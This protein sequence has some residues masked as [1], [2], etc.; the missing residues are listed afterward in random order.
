MWNFSP[1]KL[2]L[3]SVVSLFTCEMDSLFTAFGCFRQSEQVMTYSVRSHSVVH[4]TVDKVVKVHP[5][6][7]EVTLWGFKPKIQPPS[8]F[9]HWSMMTKMSFL[10]WGIL[11]MTE[12]S[13][14]KLCRPASS[15]LVHHHWQVGA[16]FHLFSWSKASVVVPTDTDWQH[17]S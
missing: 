6:C 12:G 8:F 14:M 15:A 11:M 16:L 7:K 4:S 10:V 5:D 9:K 13:F 2:C 1:Y 3:F 17:I